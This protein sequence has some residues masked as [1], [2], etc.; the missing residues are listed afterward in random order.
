MNKK[1]S[2]V[3][4]VV[5]PSPADDGGNTDDGQGGDDKDKNFTNLRAKLKIAE[6]EKE[7]LAAENEALRNGGGDR[8]LD[9]DTEPVVVPKAKPDQKPDESNE[10]SAVIF[11]RDMK[12]AVLTWNRENK[13]EPEEWAMIKKGV[14]LKGDETLS[15]I[16]EKIQSAYEALPSVRAKRDQALIDKGRKEAM[17]D[18]NDDEMDFGGQGDADMGAIPAVRVSSKARSF[19]KSMGMSDKDIQSV[20]DEDPNQWADGRKPV[21]KFFQP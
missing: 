13:V 15:E 10:V 6:A 21:R 12:E 5:N 1:E 16:K 2:D 4:G 19:A 17:R 14:N 11:K 8:S 3:D 7:R 18:F 9:L 20:G